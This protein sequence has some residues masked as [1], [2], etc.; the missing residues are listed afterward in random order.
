M[1]ALV[2][3]ALATGADAAD[4]VVTSARDAFAWSRIEQFHAASP[5]PLAV[6]LYV[7][8][9]EQSQQFYTELGVTMTLEQRGTRARPLLN[10]RR[11][12]PH[13]ASPCRRPPR[14]ADTP[15]PRIAGA[16]LSA[17]SAILTPAVSRSPITL[18]WTPAAPRT[19][20]CVRCVP[21]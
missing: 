7:A 15:D 17:P 9:P 11:P 12:Q 6:V 13:R 8:D 19:G 4:T 3:A 2:Q 18:H 21:P 10:P 14:L 1:H 16:E 5:P 20:H